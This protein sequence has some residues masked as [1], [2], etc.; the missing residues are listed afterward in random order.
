MNLDAS[1]ELLNELN[2]VA[3]SVRGVFSLGHFVDK[4]V[5]KDSSIKFYGEDKEEP[6]EYDG[7]QDAKSIIKFLFEQ[8]QKVIDGR[9]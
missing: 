9:G 8:T 6:L 4:S 7:K 3:L 1:E 2:N 5:S